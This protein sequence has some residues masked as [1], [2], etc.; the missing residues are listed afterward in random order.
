MNG[1]AKDYEAKNF[2]F[3]YLPTGFWKHVHDEKGKTAPDYSF[4]PD[5]WRSI[6]Q[7]IPSVFLE[8]ALET[9][10]FGNL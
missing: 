8:H 6:H 3:A 4:D 2:T 1:G 7:L 5:S 10:G 9:S